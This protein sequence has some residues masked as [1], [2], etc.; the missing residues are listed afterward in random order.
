MIGDSKKWVIRGT[1]RYICSQLA[2][3]S[4][5]EPKSVQ[6]VLVDDYWVMIMHEEL[7]KF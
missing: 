4:Q 5:I 6:E 3:A 2:F 7:N 1:L